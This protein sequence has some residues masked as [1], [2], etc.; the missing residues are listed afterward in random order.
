VQ[1]VGFRYTVLTIATSSTVKGYVSNLRDGTVELVLE[2]PRDSVSLVIQS[3]LDRMR[4][5][6]RG[7]TE[8]W[9]DPTGEFPDF[10]IR[11]GV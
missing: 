4:A 6:V 3:T 9:S 8:E 7:H 10:T 5:Y 11:R 2:G 1:G